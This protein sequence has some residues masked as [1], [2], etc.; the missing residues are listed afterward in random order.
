MNRWF[1]DKAKL[2]NDFFGKYWP[3][4][5]PHSIEV[6]HSGSGSMI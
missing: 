4:G 2:M 1:E 6:K 3:L 5:N